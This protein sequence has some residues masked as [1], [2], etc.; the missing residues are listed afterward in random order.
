MIGGTLAKKGTVWEVQQIGLDHLE[1]LSG[2]PSGG[3]L[4]G[5]PII[6]KNSLYAS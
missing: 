4:S 1:Q 6:L 2:S 5:L 3:V